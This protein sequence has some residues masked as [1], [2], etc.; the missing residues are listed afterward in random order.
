M[1]SLLISENFPPKV[2]G[3][4]RLYWEI[5]SRLP[6][7]ELVVAAGEDALDG[8][9][10][11]THD[12]NVWRVPL[13]LTQYGL[14][15]RTG[16]HGY[17]RAWRAL[18]NVLRQNPV[19]VVHAGRVLP[20]AWL[21]WLL[22][23][24]RGLPYLCYV[25]GE[26]VNCYAESR[27]L[28]WMARRA[29]AG[30]NTVIT[31][32][33]NARQL[34]LD[35]WALPEAKV[36]LLYPGVDTREFMPAESDEAARSTLGW[37]GRTVVLTV[38]RLQ[39]RK[40]QDMMIRALPEVREQ[41]P[42]VLYSIVGDGADR[43][44]LERLARETGMEAH[45]QFRGE[46]NDGELLKCY[47]QCELFVLANRTVGRDFEGFGIVLLEAQACGKPVVAGASGGTAETMRP[48]ATGMLVDC[49]SPAEL[50]RTVVELL[51]DSQRRRTMGHAARAWVVERFDWE[52][53]RHE[54]AAIFGTAA[55]R[56][57]SEAAA[58]ESTLEAAT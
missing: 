43:G 39:E 16:L 15:S 32:S 35:Q 20:E 3:T 4:A 41:V 57:S 23:W 38:G 7:H 33:R 26:D 45:V 11:R 58:V 27:E 47:Q 30:A 44:R 8:E 5:Y 9:F 12:L 37:Q 52:S 36:Q 13:G 6:R 28:R 42:N 46:P 40:G 50:A 21:A 29:L 31:S 1:R 53:L 55:P 2:G 49:T 54:A 18:E 14:R 17:F 51:C 48:G 34:L 22:R 56:R 10:D 19:D 24:R 25:H